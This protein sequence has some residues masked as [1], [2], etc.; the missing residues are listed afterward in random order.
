M[1]KFILL[2]KHKKAIAHPEI[3]VE[4]MERLYGKQVAKEM[5]EQMVSL[6][7]ESLKHIVWDCSHV[8]LPVLSLEQQ[9][10]CVFAYGEKDGD[11][12]L[13]K[14][15][16]PQKYPAARQSVWSGYKHCTKITEA[17]RDY[18]QHLKNEIGA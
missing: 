14:K 11:L 10:H 2:R 4:K 18:V 9:R 1:A 16:Q 13:A 6:H 17:N 15:V 5:A 12:K 7:E 3:S 8:Q